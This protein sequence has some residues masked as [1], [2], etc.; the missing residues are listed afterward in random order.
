MVVV[1]SW[2][3]GRVTTTAKFIQVGVESLRFSFR[4]PIHYSSSIP[5]QTSFLQAKALPTISKHVGTYR[6]LRRVSSGEERRNRTPRAH[7]FRRLECGA[8]CPHRCSHTRG[9]EEGPQES[10]STFGIDARRNVLRQFD[11]QNQ[12]RKPAASSPATS[13]LTLVR[14]SPSLQAWASI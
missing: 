7:R 6:Q 9:A 2:S 14:V 4:S 3:L 11:G 1:C 5:C 12:H 8:Q 10:R 13:V